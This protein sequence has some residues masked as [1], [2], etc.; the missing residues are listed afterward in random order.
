MP[1]PNSTNR[2]S[3]IRE[4]IEDPQPS[5]IPIMIMIVILIMLSKAAPCT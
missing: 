4:P 3:N 1:C 5:D 2:S